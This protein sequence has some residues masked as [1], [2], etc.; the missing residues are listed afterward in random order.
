LLEG[1]LIL[2]YSIASKTKEGF[3]DSRSEVENENFSSI[4]K[5][6]MRQQ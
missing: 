4:L 5:Q 3:N 1:V 6:L 2:F